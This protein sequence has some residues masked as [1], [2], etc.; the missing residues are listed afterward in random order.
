LIKFTGCQDVNGNDINDIS[1]FNNIGDI[2]SAIFESGRVYANDI[3]NCDPNIVLEEL[4][5]NNPINLVVEDIGKEGHEDFSDLSSF[6]DRP[7][8]KQVTSEPNEVVTNVYGT[9]IKVHRKELNL[10]GNV[11]VERAEFTIRFDSLASLEIIDVNT[12]SEYIMNYNLCP[13]VPQVVDVHPQKINV[14]K[15]KE[16]S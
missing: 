11:P 3:T 6:L 12:M 9:V 7:V 8:M 16:M 13:K 10:H 14:K 4:L 5:S 1:P 2:V 15:R